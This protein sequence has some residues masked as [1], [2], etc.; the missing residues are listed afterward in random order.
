MQTTHKQTHQIDPI[1]IQTVVQEKSGHQVHLRPRLAGRT[2]TRRVREKVQDLRLHRTP[3]LAEEIAARAEFLLPAERVLLEQAFV[4]GWPIHAIAALS[5]RPP[6]AIRRHL[7][8]L[9]D[10]VMADTYFTVISHSRGWSNEMK[11][12]G[13][14]VFIRGLSAVAAAKETGIPY[15]AAL[16]HVQTIRTLADTIKTERAPGKRGAA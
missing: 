9:A 11:A 1:T 15:R 6:R 7:K 13:A 5:G 2:R 3:T 14:A 8:R 16:L 4:Q 12:I 10:R